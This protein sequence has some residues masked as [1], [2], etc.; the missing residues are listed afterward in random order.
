MLA[1]K[2]WFSSPKE[3]FY[4]R[5]AASTRMQDRLDRGLDR[6]LAAAI[7]FGPLRVHLVP[8]LIERFIGRDVVEE[9][10]AVGGDRDAAGG[11]RL[12]EELVLHDELGGEEEQAHVV[13]PQPREAERVGR[14]AAA[15]LVELDRREVL[16]RRRGGRIG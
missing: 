6:T 14:P 7:D 3:V 9:A 5:H 13:E 12:G 15:E 11:A 16:A 1:E 2:P 8:A 10:V 4:G